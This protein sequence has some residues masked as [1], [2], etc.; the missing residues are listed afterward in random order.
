MSRIKELENEL[1]RMRKGERGV[2]V[3]SLIASAANVEGIR[4]VVSEVAGEDADGLRELA[5]ALRGRLGEDGAAVLGNAEGGRALLVAACTDHLVS[6]GVTAPRLLER[7][8]TAVGG[9]AGGK[10]VLGFAGG[11][12]SGA[13]ADALA[14]IPSRLSE[15]L[16]GV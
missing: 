5:Q 6:R 4:L 15:L 11:K 14:S 1:G 7:A 16:E 10:P 2:V 8:A 3:E 13:L 12:N 9:G